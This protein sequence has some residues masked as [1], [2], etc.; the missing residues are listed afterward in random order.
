M[1][2]PAI[3]RAAVR[4]LLTC[5]KRASASPSN[6]AGLPT[7]ATVVDSEH[8]QAGAA[9]AALRERVW[10]VREQFCFDTHALGLVAFFEQVIECC[11]MHR[12]AQLLMRARPPAR[13]QL[14]S[15]SWAPPRMPGPVPPP[16]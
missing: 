10:Q 1:P 13:G 2:D 14:R 3:G 5:R 8:S 15:H 9:P 6:L 11:R 16:A 7:T 4:A 12:P